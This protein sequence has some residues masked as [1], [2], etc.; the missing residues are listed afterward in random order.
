MSQ[1]ILCSLWCHLTQHRL[2]VT[3]KGRCRIRLTLIWF[4]LVIWKYHNL[5]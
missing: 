4:K 2:I 1:T 3:N 5:G